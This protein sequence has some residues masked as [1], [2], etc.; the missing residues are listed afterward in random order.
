VKNIV[1]LLMLFGSLSGCS[2]AYIEGEAPFPRSSFVAE[3]QAPALW[4]KV[5]AQD[6]FRKHPPEDNI[7][8]FKYFPTPKEFKTLEALI[9]PGD[10]LV[11]FKNDDW[12]VGIDHMSSSAERAFCIV[13]SERIIKTVKIWPADMEE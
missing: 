5:K 8:A 3:Y 10:R 7:A 11:E 9:Q 1:F 6:E 2:T 13:R 4:E 12:V